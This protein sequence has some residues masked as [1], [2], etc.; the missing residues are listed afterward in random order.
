MERKE[1]G[2]PSEVESG[3]FH[4]GTTGELQQTCCTG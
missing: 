1:G 4:L 3:G 2:I